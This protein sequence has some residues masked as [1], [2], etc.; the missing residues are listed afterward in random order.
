MSDNTYRLLICTDCLLHLANGECGDCHE[1]TED[2]DAHDREPMGLVTDHVTLGMLY[3][4]H[5][6]E[7]EEYDEG[8]DCEDYGFSWSSCDGCGSHLGGD[9][10]YA[11]G[12][13]S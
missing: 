6:C 5:S 9:R 10:F 3:E 2:V 1:T 11:T 13:E 12:W 4:Y 7:R 8:C